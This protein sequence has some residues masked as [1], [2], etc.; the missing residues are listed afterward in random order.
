ME[1]VEQAAGEVSRAHEQ[2][3]GQR[4]LRS[5]ESGGPPRAIRG[6]FPDTSLHRRPEVAARP[7]GWH[8][9]REK[10]GQ[11]RK[12]RDEAERPEVQ[13]SDGFSS[14]REDEALQQAA[15]PEEDEERGHG[16]EAG[17]QDAFEEQ[18]AGEAARRRAEGHA[19][20]ELPPPVEAAQ[21]QEAGDVG[22]GDEQHDPRDAA[23]P[24]GDSHG[25]RRLG[26]SRPLDGA[27]DHAR[28]GLGLA[29]FRRGG[30]E[31]GRR[32]PGRGL[33]RGVRLQA[34]HHLQKKDAALGDPIG[35]GKTTGRAHRQ[36]EVRGF[37]IDAGEAAGQHAHDRVAVAADVDLPPQN[38]GRPAEGAAPEVMAQQR[39]VAVALLAFGL[40]KEAAELRP[41][42][43]E[44]KKP[45]RRQNRVDFSCVRA[46]LQGGCGG[47]EAAESGEGADPIEIAEH[48]IGG[49]TGSEISHSRGAVRDVEPPES[50]GVLDVRRVAN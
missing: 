29:G 36:P 19:R 26:S 41:H 2:E 28:R 43:Q 35:S 50:A 8:G 11:G 13:R 44:A 12:G 3:E 33:R 39:D 7:E 42:S 46:A 14:F 47:E 1:T 22:A 48:G 23:Q 18:Q 40:R 17:Q 31:H 34:A 16:A 27:E 30:T 49:F 10:A 32:L 4:E 21:E 15:H 38:A 9:S 6:A 25:G 37:E 5:G 24:G 45:W 20:R